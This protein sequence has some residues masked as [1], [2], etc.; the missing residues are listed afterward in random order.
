MA[1]VLELFTRSRREGKRTAKMVLL[2]ALLVM[3]VMSSFEFWGIALLC[4][5]GI[6]DVLG[7]GTE[8]TYDENLMAFL[9]GHSKLASVIQVMLP[10]E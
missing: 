7:K 1:V 10:L 8:T 4:F 9:E 3:F 6:Q 2:G 5:R